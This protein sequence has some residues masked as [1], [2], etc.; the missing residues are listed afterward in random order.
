MKFLCFGS[1]NLD[2]VYRVHAIAREGETVIADSR[3]RHMGGKGLNQSVALARAGAEVYHAGQIGSEG[4]ALTDWLRENG[5]DTRFVR[6]EDC[7]TGHAIIQVD[8]NGRNCIV[9]FGGANLFVTPEWA[10]EVLSHFSGDDVLVLQNEVN[11]LAELMT[12]AK[13]RGIRVV[14]NPSPI[15]EAL[16]SAPIGLADV[17]MLNETEGCALSGTSDPGEMLDRLETTYPDAHIVLTLGEAGAMYAHGGWRDRVSAFPV[18]PVDT[19]A[20]GD[21]FTGYFLA[22]WY[23]G[24][25]AHDALL[26]ASKASAIAV[27]RPGASQSIPTRNEVAQFG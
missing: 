14:L 10:D 5:V 24:A 22:S 11:C 27:C 8:D 16:R 25:E 18:D 19:T 26:W 3:A 17:L 4:E 6:R 20:A 12:K 2:Y 9:I 13:S 1:L 21:T 15:S 7:A 23:G